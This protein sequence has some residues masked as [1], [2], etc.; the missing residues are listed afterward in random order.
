MSQMES[1]SLGFHEGAMLLHASSRY[2]TLL[3]VLFE[4]V[5]N[6]IDKNAKDIWINI[7]QK[8]RAATVRDN[9]D[10][11]TQVEFESALDSV[12]QTKKKSDALGRFGLGLVSPVGKCQ[13][14]TFTSTP[15][16]DPKNYRRWKFVH[17]VIAE[18]KSVFIPIEPRPELWFGD[19]RGRGVTAV[20]WRT[21]VSLEKYTKDKHVSKVTIESLAEGIITKFNEAMKRK[22]VV[23]YI[24]ITTEDGVRQTQ[25][26]RPKD[27]EGTKLPEIHIKGKN[28]GETV[29]H[30]YLARKTSKGSNGCVKVGEVGN[31]FRIGF[32]MFNR[33]LPVE[34]KLSDE[35]VQA[36]S[37]GIFEGDILDTKARFHSSRRGFEA[38]DFLVDF[39][40]AIDDWFIKHG[41]DP[42]LDSQET[43]KSE[44]YQS[45]GLRSLKVI[46]ALTKSDV[47]EELL[48]VINSFKVGTIGT[49]HVERPGKETHYTSAS[50][51]GTNS[52]PRTGESDRVKSPPS[53]EHEGH[54]PF[55]VIG[56][57]GQKRVAVRSGSL[58]IQLLHEV[59]DGSNLYILETDTG[60]L[61]L[62][63]RH[64]LWIQC[65]E[66]SD[67]TLM[68]FQE[69]LIL[70][71]LSLESVPDEWRDQARLSVE[72]MNGPYVF[73][74]VNADSLAGRIPNPRKN[75]VDIASRRGKQKVVKSVVIN[76]NK[77]K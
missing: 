67:K 42:Y 20:K 76:K 9:G 12:G 32:P 65:E 11:V 61:R 48:K 51:D 4:A 5:Q 77:T 68:R 39:V 73:M 70:Q 24:T 37:S 30:L 17:D 22:R 7:N 14:Y 74:L 56:P 21:E 31:D 23:V 69:Y 44:R 19:Y 57:R 47:G 75:V 50:T 66:H 72:V 54:N 53:I 34:C 13:V 64:P 45:L 38:N 36:L 10:G 60:L 8:S 25:E 3:E 55:T 18:Q 26:V 52:S 35:A 33:S 29:F 1:S 2:P 41:L 58:G 6:A 40:E 49:G 43:K 62:N 71:A 63:V 59:M 27:F 28:G 16:N 46:E 15:R